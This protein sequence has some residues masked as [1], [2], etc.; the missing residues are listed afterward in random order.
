[1][2]AEQLDFSSEGVI[3]DII[4]RENYFPTV[5]HI[6]IGE[7][8]Q[9]QRRNMSAGPRLETCGWDKVGSSCS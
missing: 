2:V 4:M 9:Q 5:A 7:W 3:Y 1:M 8:R 6:Y